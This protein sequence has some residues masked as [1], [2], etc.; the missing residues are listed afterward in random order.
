[1]QVRDK[2]GTLTQSAVI[3][4]AYIEPSSSVH[5]KDSKLNPR[6]FFFALLFL[7]DF[8]ISQSKF[9]QSAGNLYE[10]GT[11]KTID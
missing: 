10:Q 5:W 11:S 3:S 7:A 4:T 9:Y 8:F 6:G 2:P 1:M